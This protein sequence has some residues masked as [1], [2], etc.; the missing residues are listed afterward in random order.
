M[1]FVSGAR[2]VTC[3]SR[4]LY[5][6]SFHAVKALVNKGNALDL[7]NRDEEA[8]KAYEG[9]VTRFRETS[10]LALREQV[11]RALDGLRFN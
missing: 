9:V 6:M 4:K 3:S 10:E 11:T 5:R 1:V 8:V 2:R 7:V